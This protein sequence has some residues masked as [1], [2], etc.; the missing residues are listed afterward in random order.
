MRKYLGLRRD[1]AVHLIL[2]LEL[3]GIAVSTVSGDITESLFGCHKQM[4]VS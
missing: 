3:S 2:P 1:F 4:I